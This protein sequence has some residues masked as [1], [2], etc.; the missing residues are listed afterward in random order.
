VLHDG[1]LKYQPSMDMEQN[2]LT[3]AAALPANVHPQGAFAR[4]CS[5]EAS[6]CLQLLLLPPWLRLQLLPLLMLPSPPSSL[7]LLVLLLR[8]DSCPPLD[9]VVC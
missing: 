1:C 2:D 4:P 3:G 6:R 8:H 9:Q 7:Q 5:H